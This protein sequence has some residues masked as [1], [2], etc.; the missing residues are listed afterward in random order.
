L[1]LTRVK[2]IDFTRHEITVRDG[3]GRKDRVTMLPSSCKTA[4]LEHLEKVRRL[5]ESDLDQGLGQAPLPDA[6][7]R[8][9]PNADRSCG[10]QYIFPASIENGTGSD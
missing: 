10:W 6:L 8:N 7:D 5:H 1:F 2:D 9:Y 4:L 3:K